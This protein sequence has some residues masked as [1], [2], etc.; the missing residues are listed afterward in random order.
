M[1]LIILTGNVIF[2]PEDM[3]C[4]FCEKLT[5]NKYVTNI[6]DIYA[7]YMHSRNIKVLCRE[8][9]T[10]LIEC[11]SRM[12]KC[13]ECL[14]LHITNK[15]N[16]KENTD[17]YFEEFKQKYKMWKNL[18]IPIDTKFN[19]ILLFLTNNYDDV[20]WYCTLNG[21]NDISNYP[22]ILTIDQTNS[23]VKVIHE[24]EN[25]KNINST[26]MY[27]ILF[28]CVKNILEYDTKCLHGNDRLIYYLQA[29]SKYHLF[30]IW[31]NMRLSR[32]PGGTIL[33]DCAICLEELKE[34]RI[35]VY[36]TVSRMT[37]VYF[38][39][40]TCNTWSHYTC[41]KQY[42]DENGCCYVC[43]ISYSE[44]SLNYVHINCEK[45]FHN[46]NN[47]ERLIIYEK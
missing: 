45:Y 25:D 33:K 9:N 15:K 47:V 7:C 24:H 8:C 14:K 22:I 34:G 13:Q 32:I 37:N 20:L 11:P 17:I 19:E 28:P 39:C 29:T 21:M 12:Y 6:G 43:K 5:Q 26:A 4:Y 36:P 31:S 44:D 38:V 35:Q 3:K 30:L 10:I 27:H 16:T 1:E 23:L 46:L 2:E 18:Y 40:T 41:A 42:I